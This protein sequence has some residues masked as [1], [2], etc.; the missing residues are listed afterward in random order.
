MILE[1]R[2]KYM[3]QDLDITEAKNLMAH[4]TAEIEDLEFELGQS[5]KIIKEQQAEIEQLKEKYQNAHREG[6]EHGKL[7]N[8]YEVAELAIENAELQK[9]VDELK[10][11]ICELVADKCKL[12]VKE[13]QTVKGTV[14]EFATELLETKMKIGYEYYVFADNIKVIAKQKGVEVE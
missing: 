2:R 7:E 10:G 12:V 1:E 14:K 6:Y 3:S 4:Y 13:Q 8:Q 9:Q 5:N 11:K